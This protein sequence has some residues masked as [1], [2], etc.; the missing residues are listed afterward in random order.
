M[1]K[2]YL[3][4]FGLLTTAS[5]LAQKS[6]STENVGIGTQ[7]P[8]HSAVLDIQ[9][10]EKGLLI[11]RLSAKQ[12]AMISKPATGLMIYQTNESPGFYFYNGAIWKPLSDN[13]ANSVATLDINGWALDGNATATANKA[14]ATA[15]SFIGTGAGV[16]I[17]FKIG[18]FTA[19]SITSLT[20]TYLGYKSGL[21]G[22]AAANNSGFG[23]NTLASLTTG[24]LNAALGSYALEKTTTGNNNIAFGSYAMRANTVGAHNA[25]LGTYALVNN[26]TGIGNFAAGS[27]AL[28][29]NTTGN[30]NVALG[31]YALLNSTTGSN[32]TVIGSQAGINKNGS[33][34]VYIGFNTGRATASTSESNTLYIA[35]SNTTM[36]LVYG[37]FSAKYV[38]IGDVTPALRSQGT[39]T[40]GYNLLVKGGIL[41]EKVKV[42]LAAAGTDW[43]DYVFEPEYKSNMMSLEEVE[44]FTLKNKHLPN[45]PSAEEMVKTGLDVS[46]TSKMFMEKIEELTLYMIELNKEVKA[47]KAE[48]A[49]LKGNK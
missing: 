17:N 45:V 46:Q 10:T 44:Q 20:S 42:A 5:T 26:T 2:I 34:N 38:T 28:S 39:A 43:A 25:A 12:R 15:S 33:G 13:D 3:L 47:L 21:S 31:S 49:A 30:S 36:P 6:P 1:K 27:Q 35:N 29:A 23:I 32:N 8:D 41:T 40:G 9:S 37:D 18:T 22:V 7:T 48:N 16:P 11:P 4:A 14:A 24:T 19:G